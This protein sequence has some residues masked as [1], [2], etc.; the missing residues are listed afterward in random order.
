[1]EWARTKKY[2]I[3]TLAFRM[4]QHGTFYLADADCAGHTG[5]IP[6]ELNREW[7]RLLSLSGTPMFFSM[8]P[9]K[10]DDEKKQDLK[11]AFR[12]FVSI[13]EPARPLDWMDTTCP[14]RWQT[15]QGEQEFWFPTEI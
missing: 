15:Q 1:M 14:V 5:Q 6:W 9:K 11:E 3:N 2:G 4:P 8:D 7:I 10:L 12:T 13:T